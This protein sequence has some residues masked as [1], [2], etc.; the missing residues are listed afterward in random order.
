M[1]LAIDENATDESASEQIGSFVRE[2]FPVL[3]IAVL[4][5]ALHIAFSERYGI[6]R[7]E[8][9]YVACSHHPAFGYVD[10][11]PFSIAV[12]WLWRHLF[13]QSLF[14]LR[15]VP[16]VL[17]AVIIVLAGLLAQV[18]SGSR[19]AAALAGAAV[20]VA[21]VYLAVNAY[22]SMNAFDMLFWTLAALL[23]ARILR[24]E[25]RADWLA[26]GVVLGLG[27]MNKISVLWLGTGFMVGLALTPARRLFAHKD[28]WMA[29]LIAVALFVPYIL[30]QIVNHWPTLEF[31]HNASVNKNAGSSPLSFLVQVI[32]T[33]QPFAFPLW[34]A[35]LMFLLFSPAGKPFR[36]LGIAFVV[37]FVILVVN[38]TSKPEYLAPAFPMLAAAG[39]VVFERT[40]ARK[41]R[42]WLLPA[43]ACLLV[44]SGLLFA[45]LAMPI[46]PVRTYLAYAH[47]LGA[48][49]SA[50]EKQGLGQL[51]QNFADQ[52]GWENMAATVARV[53]H[54][55]PPEE[56]AHCVVYASNYGEAAAMDYFR[57]R[58]GLPRVIS[59]HNN[60][61]LWGPGPTGT[62]RNGIVIVIGG[63]RED[64]LKGFAVVEPTETIHS[65]YVMPFEDNLTVY[66]CRDLR[67]PMADSWA[68]VK[69][70]E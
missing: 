61:W 14:A 40:F 12:L 34:L 10:Q 45:P 39:G 30:W 46:L 49:P 11:P 25:R 32:L 41:R 21:P 33:L 19:R 16:A 18:M 62:D 53:Y 23:L 42:R 1:T 44:I 70:F 27:L 66:V 24:E 51:P 22:Y 58:Y 9:Y 65:A 54:R 28:L 47:A 7:D 55:L 59:G 43:Y 6:F 38:R 29:A 69:N 48:K 56:R 35:G 15:L 13:G 5:C 57:E 20:A 67:R 36:P 17:H 4:V 37:V 2:N 52:F 31:I 3:L 26:L 60:Y 50:T 8:L 63:K 64:L 68:A